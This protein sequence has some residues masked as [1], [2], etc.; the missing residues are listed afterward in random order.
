[1][2]KRAIF[3]G[4]FMNEVYDLTLGNLLPAQVLTNSANSSGLDLSPYDGPI[5]IV[6][7]IAA[8]GAG[9]TVAAKLQDSTTSGGS[10][11]DITG[12]G[13]VTTAANAA[14][15]QIIYLNSDEIRGFMRASLT[16]SGAG[17][18][19]C[20]MTVVGTKKYKP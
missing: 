9:V 17:S 10:Y 7:D 5:A 1:L 15:K 2:I 4:V 12:G 3:K 18:A 13:F 20:S 14:S 8:A 19:A 16:F 11:T 6:L